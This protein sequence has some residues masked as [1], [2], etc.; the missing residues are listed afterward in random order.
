MGGNVFD[1]SQPIK[2]ANIKPTLKEFFKELKRIFPGASE[3]LDH[4][5]LLGSA[6]KKD[7]SGDI[8][9]ALSQDSVKDPNIWG[10][11]LGRVDE[12]YREF[13]GRAKTAT[14]KQLKRR[15]TLTAIAEKA[16]KS[17]DKLTINNKNA[18]AGTIFFQF[19]QYKKEGEKDSEKKV[20]IDL[21]VGDLEWLKF[22]YYSDKYSEKN[23]KGLHRTQLIVALLANKDYTFY[24]NLGVKNK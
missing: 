10:I 4:T 14:D 7:F 20:Q 21:N 22:S 15:A 9:I 13:K 11:S 12:L 18:G 23:V 6:G 24:H 8:D 17:S 19:P 16:E 5:A 1:N 3:Y 2:K